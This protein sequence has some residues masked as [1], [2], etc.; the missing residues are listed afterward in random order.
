MALLDFCISSCNSRQATALIVFRCNDH[1]IFDEEKIPSDHL[2][3]AWSHASTTNSIQDLRTINII[4]SIRSIKSRSLSMEIRTAVTMSNTRIKAKQARLPSPD[5]L[6]R[7]RFPTS[8]PT[9]LYQ[10]PKYNSGIISQGVVVQISNQTN[11]PQP[12]ASPRQYQ[13]HPTA[14]LHLFSLPLRTPLNGS[15][16]AS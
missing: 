2:R 11:T 16:H 13:N 1:R 3:I 6:P 4:N 5:P 8:S 14:P 9:S 12:L 15:F 10:V 7:Q